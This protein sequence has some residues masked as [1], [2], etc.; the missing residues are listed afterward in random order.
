MPADAREVA[1]RREK[2]DGV[3]YVPQGH[4][5][6]YRSE[7]GWLLCAAFLLLLGALLNIAWGIV[8]LTDN[9]YFGDSLTHSHP[10]TWGWLWIIFGVGELIIATID[11]K[12]VV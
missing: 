4:V 11:R 10:E 9:F 3:I 6:T 2:I 12:S 5:H 8:G 1:P 7:T